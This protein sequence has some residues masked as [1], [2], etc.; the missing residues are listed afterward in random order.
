MGG[1]MLLKD[2]SHTIGGILLAILIAVLTKNPEAIGLAAAGDGAAKM[3]T[4]ASTIEE[5]ETETKLLSHCI[6]IDKAKV[7]K[8]H[9]IASPTL[10]AAR[11]KLAE[12]FYRQQGFSDADAF[13]HV[14]NWPKEVR[15]SNGRFLVIGRGI[16]TLSWVVSHPV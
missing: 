12:E 1:L 5:I 6:T 10:I 14:K 2:V 11:K 16:I 7:D 15:L 3:A 9:E 4:A 8:V 13:G